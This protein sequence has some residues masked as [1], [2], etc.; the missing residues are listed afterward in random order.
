MVSFLQMLS[1][2]IT[3]VTFFILKQE[4]FILSLVATACLYLV[5]V[6]SMLLISMYLVALMFFIY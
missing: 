2:R 6:L 1:A 5:M 3:Q 4:S